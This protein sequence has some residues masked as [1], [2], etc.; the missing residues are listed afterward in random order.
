[1]STICKLD[2]MVR[3]RRRARANLLRE[4]PHNIKCATVMAE[5]A[6]IHDASR[7]NGATKHVLFVRGAHQLKVLGQ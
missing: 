4:K 5:L 3:S 7:L 1:M 6:L 2:P